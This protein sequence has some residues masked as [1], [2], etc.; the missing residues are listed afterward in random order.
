MFTWNIP[1]IP[2]GLKILMLEMTF[3]EV[4]LQV[5]AT[6]SHLKLCS[7]SLSSSSSRI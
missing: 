4:L 5:W 6:A 3:F 1:F 2:I 7:S